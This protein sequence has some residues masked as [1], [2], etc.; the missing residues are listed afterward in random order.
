MDVGG[1]FYDAHIPSRRSPKPY[2]WIGTLGFKGTIDY[3]MEG[4]GAS[5][6][7]LTLFCIRWPLEAS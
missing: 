7:H 6:I 3:S 4:R 1:A 5:L 2:I